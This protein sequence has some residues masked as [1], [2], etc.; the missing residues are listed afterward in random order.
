MRSPVPVTLMGENNIKIYLKEINS[1]GGAVGLASGYGLDDRLV[2]VR[3]TAGSRS[4]AS[5]Y[6]PD[7]LWVPP[8]FLSNGYHERFPRA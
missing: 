4:F 1:R 2:G 6:R 7:R 8:S 3:V 5:P